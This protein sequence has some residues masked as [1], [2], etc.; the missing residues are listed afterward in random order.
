MLGNGQLADFRSSRRLQLHLHFTGELA[1]LSSQST[2]TTIAL[3]SGCLRPRHRT[4]TSSSPTTGI[5]RLR[6]PSPAT[7]FPHI[8]RFSPASFGLS[9]HHTPCVLLINFQL[10]PSAHR[11]LPFLPLTHQVHSLFHTRSS[12]DAIST[13]LSLPRHCLSPL[14]IR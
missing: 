12:Q 3:F 1:I 11:R 5:A 9:H 10:T 6:S 7:S 8:Y 14:D 2:Q 4:F 13:A